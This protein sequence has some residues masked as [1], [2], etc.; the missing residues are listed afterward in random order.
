MH[1]AISIKNFKN[2]VRLLVIPLLV[3]YLEKKVINKML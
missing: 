1:L 3:I 2:I